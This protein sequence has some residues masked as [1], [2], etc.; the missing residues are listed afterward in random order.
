MRDLRFE[1]SDQQYIFECLKVSNNTDNLGD[2]IYFDFLSS[3]IDL[4]YQR[5][6][7]S[8]VIMANRHHSS[9]SERLAYEEN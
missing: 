8:V 7:R 9:D 1:R 5:S 4:R 2:Y 3:L 6:N